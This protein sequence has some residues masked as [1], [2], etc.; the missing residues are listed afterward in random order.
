MEVALRPDF[1][2]ESIREFKF[3]RTRD[4]KC[5]LLARYR[6]SPVRGGADQ[7]P[8]QALRARQHSWAPSSGIRG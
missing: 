7:V 6:P 2:L 5:D 8:D 3:D 4:W 1:T